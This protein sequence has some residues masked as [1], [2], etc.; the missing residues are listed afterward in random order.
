FASN[1]MFPAKFMPSW[2]QPV[3]RV[4]PISYATDISRQLLLGSP[5]MASLGFD[6]L[7][8]GV[9]A[10]MLMVAGTAVSWKFLSR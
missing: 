3:V 10:V 8:L 4:N 1:A 6:F 5:G 7:Y 2:L 9:F